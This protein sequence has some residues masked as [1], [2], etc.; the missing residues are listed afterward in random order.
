MHALFT[1]EMILGSYQDIWKSVDVK[2]IFTEY[3]L[4]TWFVPGSEI[5]KLHYLVENDV[6]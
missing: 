3:S 5:I 1:F 2:Y 6:L 4:A